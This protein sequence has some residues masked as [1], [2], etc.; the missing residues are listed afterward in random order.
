MGNGF[1]TC[2][3]YDCKGYDD[4]AIGIKAF[5]RVDKLRIV[6]SKLSTFN[7][8]NI[9]VIIVDDD[10]QMPEKDK[11]CDETSKKLN[12]KVLKLLYNSG[13]SH[14]RNVIV[15]NTKTKYI[16]LL[17]DVV[18]SNEIS[19][20]ILHEKSPEVCDFRFGLEGGHKINALIIYAF[21][22]LTDLLSDSVSGD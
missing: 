11:L 14:G 13:L 15:K 22:R 7:L 21:P 3:W 17:D 2:A 4:I 6:L 19:L 8:G 1:G 5:T 16:L 9:D 20:A 18:I 10:P 12:L